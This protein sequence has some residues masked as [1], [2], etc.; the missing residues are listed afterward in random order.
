VIR[1]ADLLATLRLHNITAAAVE[2]AAAMEA[3]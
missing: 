2:H 1:A 3:P